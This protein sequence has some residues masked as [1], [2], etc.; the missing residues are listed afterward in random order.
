MAW[1][2][3]AQTIKLQEKKVTLVLTNISLEE[4][5]TIIGISY[6]VHFS[7]S[8]DVVPIQ[9]KVNLNIQNEIITT[10]LDKLLNPFGITYKIAN[11]NHFIL[12]K[13]PQPLTQTIRGVVMDMVTH[14]PLPGVTITIQNSNP[15]LGTTSDENGKFKIDRVPVGRITI[16]VS[17]IGYDTQTLNGLLLSS[18]KELVL[19]VSLSESTTRI[20]EVVITAQ[21]NDGIPGDGVAVTSS[22]TFSVEESKRFAGSMGDPARMASAFASVTGGSDENN[23]LI[24]RGNSPRGVL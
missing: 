21:K 2:A 18:G 24:V 17:S 20:N 15:I 13:I 8:D 19:E 22:R 7:Y 6:G 12:R 16:V 4:S 9:T 5:L 3:T 23:A 14:A 10:S 1:A 11:Q